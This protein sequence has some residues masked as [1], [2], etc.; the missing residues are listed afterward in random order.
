MS[1]EWIEENI[2]RAVAGRALGIQVMS[3]HSRHLFYAPLFHPSLSPKDHADAQLGGLDESAHQN[4]K[5]FHYSEHEVKNLVNK[6]KK[7][8]AKKYGALNS[9]KIEA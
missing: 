3:S 5:A 2:D 9:L 1:R 6:R 7:S 8:L 4:H